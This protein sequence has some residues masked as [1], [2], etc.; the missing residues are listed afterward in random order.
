[1]G[2]L[3]VERGADAAAG[4]A[5]E[6]TRNDAERAALERLLRVRPAWTGMRRAAEALALEHGSL[7]HAGPPIEGGPCRPIRNAAAVACVFEGWAG[8]LDE[9]A[10]LVDG[11]GVRLA[12][13]QDRNAA[14]PMAA[15]VSPSMRV[16]E[17]SDVAGGPARPGYAPIN[18]GGHG[19]FPAARYGRLVPEAV[20]HLRW[21]NGEVAEAL[22][23]AADAPIALLPIVDAALTEGDDGHLRHVSAAGRLREALRGRLDP[24]FAGGRVDEFIGEWPIFFLGFWMAAVRCL[25]D[26]PRGV[27]GAGLCTA[28]GGN[29]AAF[30]IEVAGLPGRWFAAPAAP[31]AGRLRPPHRPE[32]CLGAI[33]DS[34]LVEALG[35][36]AMAQ[37]YCPAMQE[38]HAGFSPPDLHELPGRM[39]SSPHPAMPASAAR[40]GISARRVVALDAAPV[41][42]LGII[43]AAAE[44]GGLGA[45]LYR[46]PLAP[47]REAVAALG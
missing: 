16:I 26:A 15:V 37:S 35:L 22:D 32:T 20:D 41:I 10:A 42:E 36:G 28:F 45:G 4:E 17:V 8:T 1:M 44:Y 33:G 40:V 46:P 12:P 3:R 11:G 13:A 25:L 2:V 23:A 47:F 9:A 18:G 34:A 29:G 24:G 14:V 39:L 6:M 21:I 7:L 38:L 43:D 27:A 5:A 31:P 19:G 30:G